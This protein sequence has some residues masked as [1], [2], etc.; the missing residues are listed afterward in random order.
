M[1]AP[2]RHATGILSLNVHRFSVAQLAL[3]RAEGIIAPDERVELI[4]G[5]LMQLRQNVGRHAATVARVGE[6]LAAA[7]GERAEVRIRHA[8]MISTHSLVIP[9]IVLVRPGGGGEQPID[10][11]D[12]LV[13]VEVVDRAVRYDRDVRGQLYNVARVPEYWIVHRRWG[14]VYRFSRPADTGYSAAEWYDRNLVVGVHDVPDL[15]FA[16]YVRDLLG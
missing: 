12:V 7:A 3:M 16:I 13:V 2:L 6:V 8:V 4:D 15:R 14:G 11:R 5:Q 9:G 1:E 10:G